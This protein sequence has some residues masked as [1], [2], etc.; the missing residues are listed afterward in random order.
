MH[1]GGGGIEDVRGDRGEMGEEV[2]SRGEG[3]GRDE[4]RRM[5]RR[6]RRRGGGQEKVIHICGQSL[7]CVL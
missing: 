3:R 7:L 1:E 6:S 4:K 2:R 5:E